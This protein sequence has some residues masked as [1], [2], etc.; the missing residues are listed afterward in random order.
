MLRAKTAP[1]LI[2]VS[3]AA[4]IVVSPFKV[5]LPSTINL[6]PSTSIVPLVVKPLRF[7]VPSARLTTPFNA[8]VEFNT[9]L[10]FALFTVKVSLIIVF[11][12]SA[13]VTVPVKLLV[14]ENVRFPPSASIIPAV[15]RPVTFKFPD[16][17][18]TVPVI[19]SPV[20]NVTFEFV[21]LMFKVPLTCV[22]APSPIVVLP[23][24]LVTPSIVTFPLFAEISPP[25]VKPSR[26]NVPATKLTLPLFAIVSLPLN[27]TLESA[28]SI[29]KLPLI[30]AITFFSI[31]VLPLKLLVP[32]TTTLPPEAAISPLVVVKPLSVNLPFCKSTLPPSIESFES[33]TMFV[34]VSELLIPNVPLTVV[35]TAP[36]IEVTPF[37]VLLPFTINCP[38]DAR[39]VP[40]VS[41]VSRVNLPISI[42]TV[43][44]ISSS[45]SRT[46][47]V[48]TLPLLS[49]NSEPELTTSF[50]ASR[51]SV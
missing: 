49:L 43:P 18:P 22:V 25:V 11:T 5:V 9:I 39:I 23:F 44:L 50:T 6:P 17:K 8:S 14:P 34:F 31:V 21:L 36:A 2:T 33:N 20:F 51:S 48:F 19:V 12:A 13:T 26:F 4:S 27:T 1:L 3:T 42:L 28:L 41:R 15:V 30:F 40:S 24:K 7:N 46:I 10:E 35:V 45:L 16:F 29:F 32:L 38:P 47:F 37:K